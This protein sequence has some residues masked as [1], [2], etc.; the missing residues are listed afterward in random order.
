MKL[1]DMAPPILKRFEPILEALFVGPK[2]PLSAFDALDTFVHTPYFRAILPQFW[3]KKVYEYVNGPSAMPFSSLVPPFDVAEPREEPE[4]CHGSIGIPSPSRELSLISSPDRSTSLDLPSSPALEFPDSPSPSHPREN[5][6]SLLLPAPSILSTPPRPSKTRISPFVVALTAPGESGPLRLSPLFT[7]ETPSG[8]PKVQPHSQL[9]APSPIIKPFSAS[10]LANKRRRISEKENQS[11]CPALSSS[12]LRRDRDVLALAEESP[13]RRLS[14]IGGKRLFA[15]MCTGDDDKLAGTATLEAEIE[16]EKERPT[17]RVRMSAPIPPFVLPLPPKAPITEVSGSKP[18]SLSPK[19][20]SDLS[21]VF[22]ES[23]ASS[24]V[25]SV[26]TLPMQR[27][28]SRKRKAMILDCVEIVRVLPLKKSQ[29]GAKLA[30]EARPMK[31]PTNRMSKKATRKRAKSDTNST[32]KLG[33]KTVSMMRLV[34]VEGLDG[35][36]DPDPDCYGGS[37]SEILEVFPD[38]DASDS[39][40]QQQQQ[41]SS[42]DD[43]HLGQVT[44]GHLISP[45][46]RRKAELTFDEDPPS[47]D[48]MFGGGEG[49]D[50]SPSR[51]VMLRRMQRTLSG[52][53]L[54][55]GQGPTISAETSP[56]QVL[57]HLLAA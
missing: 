26:S 7:P 48:S 11:P 4:E 12:P 20:P 30:T 56:M 9:L 24:K 42:D 29:R 28:A 25:G 13:S 31:T 15:E 52:S 10:P 36:G 16:K 53:A 33:R 55:A 32:A 38:S 23:D 35:E 54:K 45:A 8:P 5:H 6:V 50:V 41:L 49:G 3:P 1:V 43:P 22:L 14:T 27:T 17:K 51:E 21:S 34:P 19:A 44:P 46:L 37:D 57:R 39:S 18:V 40:C 2:K 47:D